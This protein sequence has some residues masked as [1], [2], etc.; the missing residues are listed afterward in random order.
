MF[1]IAVFEFMYN[2]QYSYLIY[3]QLSNN[4]IH[5]NKEPGVPVVFFNLQNFIMLI[6]MI[7]RMS[8][9]CQLSEQ[10]SYMPGITIDWYEPA[11]V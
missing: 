7:L 8:L 2:P 1:D 5:L 4:L 10:S 9:I 11:M 3:K 6:L